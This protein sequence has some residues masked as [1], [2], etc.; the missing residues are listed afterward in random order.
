MSTS[1]PSTPSGTELDVCLLNG[2][3]YVQ[4]TQM[5]ARAGALLDPQQTWLTQAKF[6]RLTRRSIIAIPVDA[7]N[8]PVHTIGRVQ[9]RHVDRQID[10]HLAEAS[11]DA[12]LRERAPRCEVVSVQDDGALSG[13]FT[14]TCETSVEGVLDAIVQGVKGLHLS[15]G[16]AI[17]DVWF[18]GLRSVAIPLAMPG[19]RG[20]GVARVARLRLLSNLPQHQSLMRLTV[21]LAGIAAAIDGLITFAFD[22]G[23]S[24]VD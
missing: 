2:R 7:S 18:T 21:Q 13:E 8:A 22:P 5:L 4:G 9:F 11:H 14:F 24:V 17:T 6:S 12:P 23:D 1:T 20:N 10:Y 15:L 19:F 3:H 16:P